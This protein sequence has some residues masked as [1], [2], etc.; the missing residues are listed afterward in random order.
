MVIAK[1][2]EKWPNRCGIHVHA[3][4]KVVG[5]CPDTAFHV[6]FEG[7]RLRLSY[8]SK[9]TTEHEPRLNIILHTS[10]SNH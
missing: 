1:G 7:Q 5:L 6:A 2:L 4:R 9:V 8:H 10:K 3:G